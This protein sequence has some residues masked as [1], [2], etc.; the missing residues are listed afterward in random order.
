[1]DG[2]DSIYPCDVCGAVKNNKIEPRFLYV[3]CQDHY[4]VTPT[5]IKD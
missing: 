3:V 1:M 5:H 2:Y 4:D